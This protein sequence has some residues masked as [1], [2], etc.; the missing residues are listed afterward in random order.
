M[1]PVEFMTKGGRFFFEGAGIGKMKVT[2][3]FGGKAISTE[4]PYQALGN[5]NMIIRQCIENVI[6]E[7]K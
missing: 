3:Q 2:T 4:I 7:I 1:N 5:I 6:T